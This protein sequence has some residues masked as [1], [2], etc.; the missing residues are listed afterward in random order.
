MDK[1]AVGGRISNV[2]WSEDGSSMSYSRSGKRYRVDLADGASIHIAPSAEGE[3]EGNQTRP[4]R[5]SRPARGRQR[6]R[7][8]SPDGKW[9]AVCKDYNVVLEPKEAPGAF[10]L[11]SSLF[12]Y[13]TTVTS[14]EDRKFRYG[15]A[16]WV[17]GEELD[18]QEAI[19]WSPDSGK[20][21]FYEFDE[22]R[23][24]DHYLTAG[25]TEL[26][27]S[28]LTEGYPKA[29]EPNPIA[30]LLIYDLETKQT[31]RVDGAEDDEWY[32]YGV[33]FGPQRDDVSPEL[34]F[35]RTNRHQNVLHLV[36]ADVETGQT[37]IVLTE[38]Q[39]TWQDNSPEMKFLDDGRRFIWATEKTG[40]KQYEL[41]DL[42]EGLIGT[43]TRGEYPVG[44]IETVDE[45]AGVLFYSAYSDAH[46]LNLQLHRVGLDG[47][48]QMRLT[49][50][51]F[52]HS[53]IEVSPDFKWFVAQ[54]ET[55]DTPPT[56]ALY[57]T[58]GNRIA[59]LAESDASRFGELGLEKPEL[60]SF[61]ADDGQTDLY[62][63]LFKPSNFGADKK[64]PL[65]IDVYG[66]PTSQAVRNRFVGAYAEC[67]YG[68]LIARIDNR[69]TG[70][71]GK[72]FESAVYLRLG[73]VDLKDQVDG[74][75]HLLE[76]PYVDKA[77][78]GI[79]GHSY[80]GFMAALALLKYPEVFHAAAAG[81]TVSDWRNYDTIY[82][83]RYMRTPQEN[84]KG[85]DAGSCKTYAKQLKGDLL[86]LHGMV[87]DNVHS[88]NAWQLIEL[89]QEEGKRFEMVFFP[90]AGH[91][92]GAR[93]GAARWRFLR[94]HLLN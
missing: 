5:R 8:E 9:V 14:G 73:D 39:D 34:L 75:R 52:N 58:N 63:V 57:D 50:E 30:N 15:T 69:G 89:L 61:K 21:V 72:A 94:E 47:R 83:E 32:T 23:V 29:G 60:F 45:K 12:D 87:D 33:R 81:G 35:F 26:H 91:G 48:G 82:T 37:R 74:V 1:L 51:P 78:V 76:R 36:A 41:W 85:Y 68:F 56:S 54:Y 84:A 62:G 43:L 31:I 70:N 53:S 67:E 6:D 64:Y 3:R 59:T 44:E 38:T 49:Q 90:N 66:G 24:P 55:I 27:T 88:N 28:V 42:D 77:R 13:A 22:R 92:L 93:S 25:L 18:Q 46:P 20:L 40:W 2:K 86:L 7:E 71:R 10:S 17:Y 4:Q 80:G 19:W 16:S 11:F 79:Y 65:L